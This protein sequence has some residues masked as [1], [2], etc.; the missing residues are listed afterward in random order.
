MLTHQHL[1][2]NLTHDWYGKWWNILNNEYTNNQT[3][4][5][6]VQNQ[7]Q[8]PLPVELLAQ[9]CY[10]VHFKINSK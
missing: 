6:H 9:V 5:N 3:A 8:C 4:E 10:T 7:Q 1:N 2:E